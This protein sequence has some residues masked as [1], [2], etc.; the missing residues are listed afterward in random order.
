MRGDE[1]SEISPLTSFSLQLSP[2]K[3]LP[4]LSLLYFPVSTLMASR[5]FLILETR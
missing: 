1:N 2:F 5:N 4:R 3:F